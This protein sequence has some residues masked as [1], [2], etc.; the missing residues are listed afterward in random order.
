[1]VE[2][3]LGEYSWETF[4]EAERRVSRLAAGLFSML[5]PIQGSITPIAIFSET[6]AEWLYAAQAAFRLNRPLVTLYA[7]LGDD[8]LV[9]G[10]NEAEVSLSVC[11]HS[12][13]CICC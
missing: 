11:I 7:T 5:G 2:L 13:F 8:A 10:F 4:G 12:S 9:H 1:M 6:R 3:I